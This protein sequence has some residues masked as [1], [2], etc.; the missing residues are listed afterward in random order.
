MIDFFVPGEPV[1]KARARTGKGFAFTPVRTKAWEAQ[2][3]MAAAAARLKAGAPMMEGSV[4]M[5]M[6]FNMPTKRR[7][8]IDNLAKSVLDACNGVLYVDDSQVDILRVDR[9]KGAPAHM[10]GVHVRCR[11]GWE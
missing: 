3:K 6:Y 1:P 10:A 11:K 9:V 7:S 5:E 2:V 4:R 8:D